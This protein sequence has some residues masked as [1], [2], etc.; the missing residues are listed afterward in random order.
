MVNWNSP[1]MVFILVVLLAGVVA[2]VH[3]T[4]NSATVPKDE[5]RGAVSLPAGSPPDAD[6]GPH[7]Q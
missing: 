6:F 1:L 2:V 3:L 4:G 5:L 7:P